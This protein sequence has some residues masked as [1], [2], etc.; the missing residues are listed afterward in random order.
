MMLTSIL[1]P[2]FSYNPWTKESWRINVSLAHIKHYYGYSDE[3]G[4]NRTRKEVES[5]KGELEG[6][7]QSPPKSESSALSGS[8]SSFINMQRYE[9]PFD[10]P[11]WELADARERLQEHRLERFDDNDWEAYW[12]MLSMQPW[13]WYC[14]CQAM[15]LLYSYRSYLRWRWQK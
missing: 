13:Q 14:I 15:Y 12:N 3:W 5:L 9:L 4:H 10:V 1:L 7:H 6:C 2:T 11:A 8:F